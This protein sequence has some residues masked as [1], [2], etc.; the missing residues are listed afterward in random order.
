MKIIKKQN[1]KLPQLSWLVEF[2][3]KNSVL[4]MEFGENVE[5]GEAFIVEGVWDGDFNEGKINDSKYLFGSG[6][7]F[8]DSSIT[9]VPSSSTTDAIFYKKNN[10]IIFAANS[11]PL[12]LACLGDQ[13]I[14]GLQEYVHI[15][16]SVMD[17][18]RKYESKIPTVQGFVER[19]IYNNLYVEKDKISKIEK[20]KVHKFRNYQ[21]YKNY[22]YSTYEILFKNSQSE[23][24]KQ[25]LGVISIQSRGYDSTATNA[26]AA[27]WK[28]DCAYT[29][30]QS[31]GE[32]AWALN[33]NEG[34]LSDDGSNI[35]QTLNIP[36]KPINRGSFKRGFDDEIWFH[37]ALH[38]NED[39]NLLEVITEMINPRIV[40][41][42]VYGDLMFAKKEAAPYSDTRE[43]TLVRADLGTHGM[44]EIRL[45]YGIIHIAI[46]A[47]GGRSLEYLQKISE[48][49][50]MLPWSL[51]QMYNR[52]IARRLAEEEGVG[53]E[54]F[55]QIKMASAVE[56]PRPTSPVTPKLKEESILIILLKLDKFLCL[57]NYAGRYLLKLITISIFIHQKNIVLYI[58]LKD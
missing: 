40:L 27:N 23:H 38:I 9:L 33:D 44:S 54:M 6:V 50:E 20:G 24:R 47:I 8:K 42:G 13:L 35:C 49:D 4:M 22:L 14:D 21:E 12:L 46:P 55:G 1:N 48:S 18:I 29:V 51:D 52:P 56:L 5:I 57:A 28:I 39:M 7:S 53:R 43:D 11:L 17:G 25:V 36:C 41:T 32:N 2:D 15:N 16:N 3:I 26:I 45:K 31:K 34:Q 37:A 30:K 10:D 19:L 58:I